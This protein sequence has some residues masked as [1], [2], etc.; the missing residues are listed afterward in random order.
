MGV[1][2]HSPA[3]LELDP[4]TM[5]NVSVARSFVRRALEP[6]V[7]GDVVADLQLVTSEL[8][9]NAFEHGAPQPVL[10]A[11]K[12]TER[13]ASVTIRSHLR[14]GRQVADVGEWSIAEPDRMA[15]RGLGI[16]RAVADGLEVDNDGDELTITVHRHW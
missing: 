14:R 3:M 1:A 13:Q 5:S 6:I 4:G 10:V 2:A 8:V 11:V 7:P 15:G 12:A 9:T 16:V